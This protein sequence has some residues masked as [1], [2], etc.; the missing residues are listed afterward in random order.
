MFNNY[1]KKGFLLLMTVLGTQFAEAQELL[2]YWHFNML[3]SGT[4]TAAVASDFSI[5][6]SGSITY[7]GTGAGYLD[8]VSPGDIL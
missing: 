5:T 7:N 4:I 8:R 1:T 3:P 6:G 2:H